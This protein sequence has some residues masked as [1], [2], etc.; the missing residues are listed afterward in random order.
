MKGKKKE[1]EIKGIPEV[2]GGEGRGSARLDEVSVSWVR[3]KKK[4]LI[5][6]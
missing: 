5:L 6:F 1:E 3:Q 2:K 4:G